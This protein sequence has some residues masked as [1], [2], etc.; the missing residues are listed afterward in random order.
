MWAQ[1]CNFFYLF[2]LFQQQPVHSLGLAALLCASSS[3]ITQPAGAKQ[4]GSSGSRF[5]ENC[6]IGLIIVPRGAWQAGGTI[7]R[8]LCSDKEHT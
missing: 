7:L 2:Q 8:W 1:C 3:D 6:I 5:F 4:D